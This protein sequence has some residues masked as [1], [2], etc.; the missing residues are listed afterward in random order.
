MI[1]VNYFSLIY[2]IL[3]KKG[4]MVEVLSFPPEYINRKKQYIW[5]KVANL[6]KQ[7]EWF[8]NKNETLKD[9]NYDMS[10]SFV[11]SI[12]GLIT[13]GIISKENW[14]KRYFSIENL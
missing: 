6:E 11:V 12:A 5:E 2:Y 7:I 9:M 4:E 1:V 3:K 10:D 13:L 14:K 8:Y